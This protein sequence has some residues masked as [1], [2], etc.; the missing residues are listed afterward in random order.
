MLGGNRLEACSNLA[1]K[2][3]WLSDEWAF[4]VEELG[5]A[6]AVLE[7][8]KRALDEVV[9][10]SG[11]RSLHHDIYLHASSCLIAAQAWPWGPQRPHAAHR[12]YRIYHAALAGFPREV[13]ALPRLHRDQHGKAYQR[14]RHVLDLVHASPVRSLASRHRT[15][16]A[17]LARAFFW[18]ATRRD[19]RGRGEVFAQRWNDVHA[20]PP[21]CVWGP[22]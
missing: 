18:H 16:R 13:R 3:S 15:R 4:L 21:W 1:E 14:T 2:L 17:S 9:E 6:E 11:V 5:S 7:E 20:Q 22:L 19:S 8:C 12:R 10:E